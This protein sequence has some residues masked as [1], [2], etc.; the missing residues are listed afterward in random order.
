MRLRNLL[1][2]K[3]ATIIVL[4]CLFAGNNSFGR[5]MKTSLSDPEN[6]NV[7]LYDH[8]QLAKLGLQKHI[9][10][11]ALAG[12]QN[13]KKRNE[14]GRPE[15]ISIA[16][17]SQSSNAKR[18]YVIDLENKTVLFNTYVSH[19]RN[20][21]EEYA[22]S[23]G[24]KPQCYKSSLGFYLTGNSYNGAHG[25]SM[26]LK[27]L[28]KDI[29]HHAEERG[30]VVHGAPYVSESFIQA[31]GRLGRSQGCPAVPEKE[32]APIVNSIKEGSCFFIF[33][34]DSGYFKRSVYYN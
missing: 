25:L 1:T 2:R 28:E 3:N 8:L 14:L 5:F 20:S 22:S 26:R 31:N 29:N 16:D 32:C 13:M 30:I 23:F 24:N 18:L 34:P 21:G 10:E 9:F 19:G 15:L 11:R 12:W 17:L 27:G 4:F 7:S 6:V 33:Y